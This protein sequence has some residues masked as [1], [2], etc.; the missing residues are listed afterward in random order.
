MIHS[1]FTPVLIE[2][3]LPNLTPERQTLIGRILDDRTRHFTMVI[4]DIFQDHNAGAVI[5]TCDCMGI[6][7]VHIIEND[8]DFRASERLSKG[9]LKWIDTHYYA[10]Q[11]GGTTKC[12][13][14]LRQKG[15]QIIATTP[16]ED[17]CFL[18]DFDITKKSAFFLGAEKK[19]VS[20]TVL[21][22]ADGFLRIPMWGT[23]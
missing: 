2:L 19:G 12:I 9:A 3:L 8:N 18:E 16:H 21:N 1:D 6:Q 22:Q 10:Q 14:H 17:D 4:E 13:K 5:R 20:K 11:E 15:Y 7:D 23:T